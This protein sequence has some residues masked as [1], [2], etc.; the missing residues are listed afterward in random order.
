MLIEA[1]IGQ[2]I[3]T[4]GADGVLWVARDA[5]RHVA[6]L[7]VQPVD[8]TGAGDAFIG[9]FAQHYA[10]SRDVAAALEWAN[11]YAALSVTRRGTQTSFADAEGFA[12][13]RA[14]SRG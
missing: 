1:G 2:V 10:E 11:A 12:Q 7:T 14:G 5:T 4:L 3:V 6:P 9:S 8:T 13:F